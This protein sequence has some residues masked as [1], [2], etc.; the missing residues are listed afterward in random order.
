MVSVEKMRVCLR[1]GE[2]FLSQSSANRI[3]PQ[4]KGVGYG[5][6]AEPRRL[7]RVESKRLRVG[8]AVSLLGKAS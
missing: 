1:C 6:Y 8:D 2:E 5:V 3:C 7:E 4:C